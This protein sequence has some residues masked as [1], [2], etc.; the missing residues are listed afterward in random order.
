MFEKTLLLLALATPACIAGSAG[1]DVRSSS[2]VTFPASP[3]PT[4]EAT[5]GSDVSLDVHDQLRSL[6]K[7]GSLNVD[8]ASDALS[9][10]DLS[11]I[12][13]VT[14][15]IASTDGSMPVEP[16][17]HAVLTGDKTEVTLTPAM[18]NARIVAYLESGPVTLHFTLT[19]RLPA[20]SIQLTHALVVHVDLSVT[21]SVGSI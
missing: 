15:T 3:V 12:D 6:G 19:G 4:A 13:E 18:S 17:V 2:A 11:F 20:R 14:G 8:L 16:F 9:G 21:S 5:T 7:V 1:A 10:D